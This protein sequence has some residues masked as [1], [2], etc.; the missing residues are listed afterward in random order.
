MAS[1]CFIGGPQWRDISL[2]YEPLFL[3]VVKNSMVIDLL[4]CEKKAMSSLAAI[5]L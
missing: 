5:S 1:S 4:S 3:Q 2:D